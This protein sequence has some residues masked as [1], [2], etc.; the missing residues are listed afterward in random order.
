M[1][2]AANSLHGIVDTVSVKHDLAPYLSLLRPANGK[3]VVVGIPSEPYE[4]HSSALIFS[5][6]HMWEPEKVEV[7][8]CSSGSRPADK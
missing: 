7:L 5:K 3:Y 2:A 6:S 1:K 8:G 4:L